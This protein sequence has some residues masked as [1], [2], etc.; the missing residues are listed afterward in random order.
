[1]LHTCYNVGNR[2]MPK[3]THLDHPFARRLEAFSKELKGV[4]EGDVEAVHHARVA[5]R[6]LRELLPLLELPRDQTQGLAR[7]LRKATK[8]LGKVRELDVQ[9]ALIK[10][11]REGRHCSPPALAQLRKTAVRARLAARERLSKKCPVP[12]LERLVGKLGRLSRGLRDDKRSRRTAVTPSTRASLW[13]LD[14]RM[15]RRAARVRTSIDAVGAL[16][17]PERLHDVRL[18]VKKLLYAS[19][20]VAEVTPRRLDT[21]IAT[22]KGAQD[23]LGRLHDLEML[24]GRAREV[25]ASFPLSNLVKWRSLDSVVS[26]LE[27]G[28][29]QLH[30]RYMRERTGLIAVTSRLVSGAPESE[31]V[32]ERAVS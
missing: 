28:C 29:R 24:L 11:L 10:E 9:I 12:T 20:L 19:E 5:S 16:Y 23:L 17:A 14:A 21:D 15:A 13:A 22:L 7:R 18:A 27:Q 30:A 1:M 32:A 3:V 4:G 26:F 8:Q 6:R 25:Q 2:R 31:P